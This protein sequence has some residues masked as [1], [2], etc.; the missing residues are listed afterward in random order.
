MRSVGPP[1]A[2]APEVI[3]QAIPLLPEASENRARSDADEPPIKLGEEALKVWR[4]DKPKFKETGELDRSASLVK[5]GRVLFD[6][7]AN[8]TVLVAALR[9]RDEALGWRKYTG[10]RDSEERYH[11]IVDELEETGRT[12]P[13]KVRALQTAS[14]EAPPSSNG[15]STGESFDRH[16]LTDLGNSERFV[17]QHGENVRYCYP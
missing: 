6:A 12:Q 13:L 14:G 2:W 3:D 4:G 11:E 9:E 15:Q 5:I 16:N 7:G 1:L 10:R 8:R 17:A